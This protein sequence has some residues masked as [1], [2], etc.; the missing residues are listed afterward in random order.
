MMFWDQGSR[1]ASA[2]V[3]ILIKNNETLQNRRGEKDASQNVHIKVKQLQTQG[4]VLSNS[5]VDRQGGS[6]MAAKKKL[7]WG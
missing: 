5:I 2:K 1:M 4:G 3:D 6:L 7:I